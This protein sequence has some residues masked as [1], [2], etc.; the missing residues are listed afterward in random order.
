MINKPALEGIVN[1]V[2]VEMV[3]LVA[4]LVRTYLKV[5]L[6]SVSQLSVG[7]VKTPPISSVRVVVWEDPLSTVT[8]LKIVAGPKGP[9]KPGVLVIEALFGPKNVTGTT[10]APFEKLTALGVCIAPF[11]V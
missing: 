4:G 11:P 10:L 1:G 3:K 2:S 8:V 5:P 7:V 6:R 9:G